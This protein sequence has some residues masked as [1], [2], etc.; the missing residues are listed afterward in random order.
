MGETYC[1]L[2]NPPACANLN[3]DFS[4]CGVCGNS[5]TLGVTACLGGECVDILEDELNCGAVGNECETL[6]TCCFGSCKN[7]QTDSANCGECGTNCNGQ[8]CENGFC[9]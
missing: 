5:C 9:T 2:N 8:Y 4:N 3:T 6:E 7:L 1:I